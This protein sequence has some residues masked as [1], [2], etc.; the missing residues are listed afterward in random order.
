MSKCLLFYALVV[1]A[2][3]SAPRQR[4]GGDG[5]AEEE[6][7]RPRW[8]VSVGKSGSHGDDPLSSSRALVPLS[9]AAMSVQTTTAAHQHLADEPVNTQGAEPSPHL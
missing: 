7:G 8:K 5:D 9:M 1:P 3:P 6:A 4:S 2:P